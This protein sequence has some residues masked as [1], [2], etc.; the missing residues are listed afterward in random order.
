MR[1][2]GVGAMLTGGVVTLWRLRTRIGAALADSLK[3]LRSR[4]VIVRS[5]E[6]TDLSA[7]AIL[8]AVALVVPVIFALCLILSGSVWLSLSL[9]IVLTLVG[10]FATAVAGYLTGIVGARTIRS[11]A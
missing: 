3:V 7:R 9:A 5:R 4:E 2:L 8:A 10:F 11:R 6:D 1:Y